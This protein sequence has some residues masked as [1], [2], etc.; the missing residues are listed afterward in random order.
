MPER[1]YMKDFLAG[2]DPTG[3]KTFQYGQEDAQQGERSGARRAVGTAGGLL[4]GAAV[5][6]AAVGGAVGGVKGLL[7]GR[8]NWKTRLLGAGRGF[9][10]GA[11]KPYT[12]L[13]HG[14]QANRALAAHQ[15]GKTLKPRQAKQL[16]RFVQESLP[17]SVTSSGKVSPKMVQEGMTRL[18]PQQLASVRRELG[19][20]VGA[21]AAALGLSGAISGGSAYAQYGKGGTTGEQLRQSRVP[22][23][24]VSHFYK[25]GFD[26][27]LTILK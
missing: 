24:K 22:L 17:H 2:V 16:E 26:A 15:A 4:G 10:S 8:G 5:I 23:S 12:S 21:G 14:V 7:M 9:V 18:N 6:P 19:G 13:Y 1:S 20:E 11:K 27:V 25:R 3:T